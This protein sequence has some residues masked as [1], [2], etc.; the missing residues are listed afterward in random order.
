MKYHSHLCGQPRPPSHHIHVQ[1]S[2]FVSEIFTLPFRLITPFFPYPAP[3]SR[4]LAGKQFHFLNR[5]PLLPPPSSSF[6]HLSSSL[7]HSL[8]SRQFI[9]LL[10]SLSALT[11]HPP[12]TSLPSSFSPLTQ[13]KVKTG[14][15]FHPTQFLEKD[16]TS[17]T[18]STK[19]SNPQ[20]QPDKY[21]PEQ[22]P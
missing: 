15:V 21:F 12:P 11:Y 13:P 22:I 4:T 3:K 1:P 19:K 7:S 14:G 18:T 16:K 2:F 6:L 17:T 20:V 9:F 5:P 8:H 10:Q